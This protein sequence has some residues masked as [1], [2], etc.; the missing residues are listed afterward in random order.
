[1]TEEALFQNK[2]KN[3]ANVK[4]F[5]GQREPLSNMYPCKIKWKGDNFYSSESIYQ[6]EKC[7]KHGHL[8]LAEKVK[9]T[10]NAFECKRLT[11]HISIS[12]VWKNCNVSLMY[13]ILKAK[14]EFCEEYRAQISEHDYFAEDTSDKFWARHGSNMLGR[15]HRK[16]KINTNCQSC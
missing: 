13:K 7:L 9:H 16:I 14:Y 12:N 2:M 4:H 15:I 8:L 1:M 5:R 10:K 11:K 3:M 6:H